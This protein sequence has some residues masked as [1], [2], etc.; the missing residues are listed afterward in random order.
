MKILMLHNKD[1]SEGGGIAAYI[2]GLSKRLSLNGNRVDIISIVHN[3]EMKSY[4]TLDGIHFHRLYIPF[5]RGF[6]GY[7]YRYIWLNIYIIKLHNKINFDLIC[8][9]TPIMYGTLKYNKILKEIPLG[10]TLHMSSRTEMRYEFQKLINTLPW[11]KKPG[12]TIR[13]L[14]NYFIYSRN[15]K[16]VLRVSKIII[17]TTNFV[18][19]ILEQEHGRKYSHKITIIPPGVDSSVFQHVSDKEQIK[20]MRRLLKLPQEA[21]IFFTLRRLSPRMGLEN[22]I[23]AIVI[24][25]NKLHSLDNIVFVIGGEGILKRRLQSLIEK[26]NLSENVRLLGFL[27]EEE[28]KKYLQVSNCAIIPTEGLEG[29]GIFT[30]EALASGLPVIGTPVGGTIELLNQVNKGALLTRDT[31]PESIADK[32]VYF[33]KNMDSFLNPEE[34]INMVKKNYSWDKLAIEVEEIYRKAI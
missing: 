19:K 26:Y 17:V 4:E 13:F 22:L 18:K 7:I 6:I 11:Y 20:Q 24:V 9:H 1:I 10:Y 5:K 21:I 34:Y 12:V 8:L 31:T 25:Q 23:K 27:S 14:F 28:K 29:F 33:L 30:V 16:G 2:H 32:I 3:K 15:E